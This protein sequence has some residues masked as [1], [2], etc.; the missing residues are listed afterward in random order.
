MLQT[1]AQ[2]PLSATSPEADPHSLL[3]SN[4]PRTP[5]TE[6]ISRGKKL[7]TD[8]TV[9]SHG[10]FPFCI[11]PNPPDANL[12]EHDRLIPL[13][14]NLKKLSARSPN[15]EPAFVPDA[16]PPGLIMTEV[17][18]APQVADPYVL[19]SSVNLAEIT[20]ASWEGSVGVEG[21]AWTV[22]VSMA[23]SFS[24]ATGVGII[25]ASVMSP[26]AGLV[27]GAVTLGGAM[28]VLLGN[29]IVYMVVYSNGL[30]SNEMGTF[31]N[32]LGFA[33]NLRANLAC[34]ALLT[35]G[36][37]GY[38]DLV[39]MVMD[40]EAKERLQLIEKL[41]NL[42]SERQS[43]PA[44]G[45]VC[46]LGDSEFT[47]WHQLE[48]D[49]LPFSPKCFNAGFGGA[50][51]ID[52][53]RNLGP[54]C[55]DWDPKVVIVHAGGN[56]FDFNPD[57]TPEVVAERIVSLFQTICLHPSVEEVGYLLSSRRPVYSDE[58][59]E[60]MRMV[61]TTTQAA[62]Q[63][64]DLHN[65]VQI[66]DLRDMIHPLSDFVESDRVHLNEGGHHTK[67]IR[68][69]QMLSLAWPEHQET[70]LTVDDIQDLVRIRAMSSD[71]DYSTSSEPSCS[72]SPES[73]HEL[74]IGIAL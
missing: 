56:D 17:G 58:K 13:N 28:L 54:L 12:N 1:I 31:V 50:R 59:W 22:V 10:Q 57:V 52:L 8:R 71:S 25:I 9:P 34:R 47:F 46:F 3:D 18:I 73:R 29:L 14:L 60:Y 36:Y 42:D 63:A 49:M 68:L 20:H 16:P 11:K 51:T 4:S 30:K 74:E 2:N 26:L 27:W 66:L 67:S 69:V 53:D 24:A 6:A 39:T 33:A 55:L 38:C 32:R 43:G 45:G 37:N 40:G 72:C 5:E 64:H 44:R 41:P 70:P 15:E 19:P 48:Q 23:A 7:D 62:I 61:H 35:C 21:P 65:K